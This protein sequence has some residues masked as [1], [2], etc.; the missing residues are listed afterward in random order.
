[1][2]GL[3]FHLRDLIH[4]VCFT[5]LVVWPIKNLC[6]MSTVFMKSIC[7]LELEI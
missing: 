3:V 1:M 4:R 2:L 6:F 7:L 5:S